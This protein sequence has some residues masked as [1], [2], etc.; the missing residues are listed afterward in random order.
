MDL[1]N[2]NKGNKM[3]YTEAKEISNKLNDDLNNYSL[4]LNTKY[5]EKGPM[6]LTPDHIKASPEYKADKLNCTIAF[7]A[8]RSFNKSF[9]KVFKKEIRAERRLRYA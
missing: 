6:G 5:T 7:N 2:N 9:V 4:I 8:L 3:N 1:T